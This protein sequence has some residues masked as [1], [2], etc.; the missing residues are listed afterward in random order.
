MFGIRTG[1]LAGPNL[2]AAL[3]NIAR[4]YYGVV[5]TY[6][7]P[8]SADDKDAVTPDMLVMGLVKHGVV[9]FAYPQDARRNLFIQRSTAR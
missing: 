3:E 6:A 4:T 9:T 5:A 7:R 2:K 1:N 8:F